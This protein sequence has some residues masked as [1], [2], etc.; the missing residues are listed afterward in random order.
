MPSASSMDR[1]LN[2][3]EAARE[4]SPFL[5]QSRKQAGRDTTPTLTLAT[6][7]SLPVVVTLPGQDWLS[8]WSPCFVDQ[9]TTSTA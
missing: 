9:H 4:S 1:H 8:S 7:M 2:L 6:L 5:A 3:G